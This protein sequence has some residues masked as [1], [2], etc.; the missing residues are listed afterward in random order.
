MTQEQ[1]HHFGP[2]QVVERIFVDDEAEGF[3]ALREGSR[4][5]SLLKILTPQLSAD[6]SFDLIYQD[7][8]QLGRELDLPG[9]MKVV[10]AG[11]H[12][13]CRYLATEW[14]EGRSLHQLLRTMEKQ[15]VVLPVEI[16]TWLILQVCETLTHLHVLTGRSGED[17]GIVH[18]DLAP[19]TL[20]LGFD[21]MPRLCDAR[22][23]RAEHVEQP[24]RSAARVG[25]PAYFA[26]E[27]V[28]G[29][30]PSVQ[31]DLW[32][33]GVMLWELL[34]GRGLFRG[35]TR[36]EV[37]AEVLISPIVSPQVHNE[38]IDSALSEI[39]LRALT[40][41]PERRFQ[42][43]SSLAGALRT[44]LDQKD[45][46]S[47]RAGVVG[48]LDKLYADETARV[49]ALTAPYMPALP[50]AQDE[51][52]DS[53]ADWLPWTL[54]AAA[55]LALGTVVL[56]ILDKD[57][58]GPPPVTAALDIVEEMQRTYPGAQDAPGH[59]QAGWDALMVGEL[60][61]DEVAARE[62][63]QALAA[64][65]SS[66][67]ASAGLALA[68]ARLGR[69]RA[70]LSVQSVKLLTRAQK[71]D[72]SA[73]EVLRAEPG[74]A[75]AV[76]NHP[77]ATHKARSCLTQLP[78]DPFCTGVQGLALLAQDRP[79]DAFPLLQVAAEGLPE[80][81]RLLRATGEAALA[82][83]DLLTAHAALQGAVAG[84]PK[85]PASHKAM[86]EL[87]LRT[88]D[89]PA[90]L[91]DTERVLAL[92]RRDP[93]ARLIRGETLLHVQADGTQAVQLLGALAED[94]ECPEELRLRA[95]TGAAF[96]ALQI[97][98]AKE[99]ERHA[100]TALE[101]QPGHATAA[102]ALGLALCEQGMVTEGLAALAQGEPERLPQSERAWV[103]LHM[104]VL[105]MHHDAL[106]LARPNLEEAQRLAPYALPP[107]FAMAQLQARLQDPEGAL[108]TLEAGAGIDP[109]IALDR[110]P[111]RALPAPTATQTLAVLTEL[112][113]SRAQEDAMALLDGWR[114]LEGGSCQGAA[115]LE[116]R[117]AAPYQLVL[118]QVLMHE[119][120]PAA[121][122]PHLEAG[123]VN[124][125]ALQADAHMG[126]G[127]SEPALNAL[128]QAQTQGP[129]AA[130]IQSRR[131]E[132]LLPTDPGGARSAARQAMAD[133]PA[134]LRAAALLLETQ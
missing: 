16:S 86:A 104:G 61:Q 131:A 109:R 8:V 73:P 52:E 92:D 116:T 119:Q 111:Q 106:A 27:R 13:G 132:L 42:S 38:A 107:I 2:Y 118:A 113:T 26:P 65:P 89:W 62:L 129:S 25:H 105:Q 28:K 83:G 85:D 81:D 19:S 4:Q 39:V 59:T 33:V 40:R 78:Q 56:L 22:M 72:P 9:V 37:M 130:A 41:P 60:S 49:Q 71:L 120:N 31:T 43:A 102:L 82:S 123:G 74:I 108:A 14:V 125:W 79:A 76:A 30:P 103:K 6:P 95:Q 11:T 122:L 68:Y 12:E 98:R 63:A 101:T 133:D 50:Q 5:I 121:A 17:L 45:P 80:A 117:G 48:I 112:P 127:Q 124:R 18:H 57:D 10:D 29:G 126:L 88:G 24:E 91:E 69:E 77:A 54:A 99:A 51:G 53:G 44:W 23:V 96:A 7:S 93:L 87:H 110:R 35:G 3:R 75:L 36:E 97:G 70:E 90:L 94:P 115:G 100:R 34:T 66:A 64:D 128:D 114:C 47:L 84:L 55:L 32:A 58:G 46:G 15:K 20:V 1:T 21:G 134:N 67:A